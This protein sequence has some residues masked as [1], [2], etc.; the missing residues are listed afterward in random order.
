MVVGFYG[1]SGAALDQLCIECAPLMVVQAGSAPAIVIG[2]VTQMLSQGGTG[3]SAFDEQCPN[4]GVANGEQGS[5][6]PGN[7]I[8]SLGL[9]CGTPTLV[10]G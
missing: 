3:G 2:S 7:F 9:V 1:R 10:G 6:F 4:G 8:A 5:E